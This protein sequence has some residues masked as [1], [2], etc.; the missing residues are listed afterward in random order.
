MPTLL[1]LSEAWR[2]SL[3]LV[4]VFFVFF[5]ILVQGLIMFAAAVSRGEHEANEQRKARRR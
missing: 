2:V 1:G 5:P 4:A 3:G